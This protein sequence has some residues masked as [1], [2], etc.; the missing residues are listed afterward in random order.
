MTLVRA[1]Y[2]QHNSSLVVHVHKIRYQDQYKAKVRATLYNKFNC[3]VYEHKNYTLIKSQ[4]KG[5][6]YHK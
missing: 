5:W 4:I 1:K 3:I 6:K 2:T